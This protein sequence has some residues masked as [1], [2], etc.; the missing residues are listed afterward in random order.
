M[1]DHNREALI[2]EREWLTSLLLRSREW[3]VADRADAILDAGFRRTVQGEP[4]VPPRPTEDEFASL[5]VVDLNEFRAQSEPTDAQVE[6]ACTAFYEHAT[7]LTSWA[8]LVE[9]DAVL[10]DRYRD[11]IRRAL[12]AAAAVRGG[13]KP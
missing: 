6:D 12:R 4:T 7:G 1:A 8:R 2:E 13:G 5:P 10:A 11:G 9:Y 3:N